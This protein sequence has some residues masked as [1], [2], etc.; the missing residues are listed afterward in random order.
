MATRSQE[1]ANELLSPAEVRDSVQ[2]ARA[3]LDEALEQTP[4]PDVAANTVGAAAS[5]LFALAR[6]GYLELIDLARAGYEPAMDELE[7]VVREPASLRG[8]AMNPAELATAIPDVHRQ[9]ALFDA[10]SLGPSALRDTRDYP[11]CVEVSAR[12]DQE[13]LNVAERSN[14]VDLAMILCA[15]AEADVA[16]RASAL[17]GRALVRALEETAA[18]PVLSPAVTTKEVIRHVDDLRQWLHEVRNREPLDEALAHEASALETIAARVRE[19]AA[20]A[21]GDRL[22]EDFQHLY[23][24][25]VSDVQAWARE[26][27]ELLDATSRWRTALVPGT[28]MLTGLVAEIDREFALCQANGVGWAMRSEAEAVSAHKRQQRAV[29]WFRVMLVAAALAWPLA[30]VVF[31]IDPQQILMFG[32]LA[33]GACGVLAWELKTV[34]EPDAWR[35]FYR[36]P[37]LNPP[38]GSVA[39][40]AKVEALAEAEDHET[41]EAP[42]DA[43]ESG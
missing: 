31:R 42:A 8:M 26:R 18:K 33:L 5:Y 40:S 13:L 36:H 4:V 7:R 38:A 43:S 14:D 34:R 6:R 24:S 1:R 19:R 39:T 12:I 28:V 9:L 20:M 41:D 35:A 17:C 37:P 2:R 21:I 30:I 29:T 11:W 15:S 16:R 32:F 10:L 25:H 27:Q 22:F 3:K 23:A